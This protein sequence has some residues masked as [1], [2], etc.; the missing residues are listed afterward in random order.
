M[1]LTDGSTLSPE[2]LLGSLNDGVYAFKSDARPFTFKEG[3]EIPG[4]ALTFIAKRQFD[5]YLWN[6]IIPLVLITMMFWVPFWLGEDQIGTRVGVATSSI[7]TLIAYRFV[8]SDL[9][10]RLP[11]MTRMDYFTVGSTVLVLLALIVVLG[12]SFLMRRQRPKAALAVDRRARVV[13]PL[14]FILMLWWFLTGPSV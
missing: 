3:R 7:L 2:R 1:S 10:P 5:Y 6:V 11:Y 12:T 8:L 9:L 4:C 14:V 13:F